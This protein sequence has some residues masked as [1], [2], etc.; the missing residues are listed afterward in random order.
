M[1]G[2]IKLIG[3]IILGILFLWLFGL[4][5]IIKFMKKGGDPCPSSLS[6]LVDLP[7]RRYYMRHVLDRVG[8]TAG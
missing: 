6:W 2:I 8:I 7:I 3:I 5:L 1:M 4:K